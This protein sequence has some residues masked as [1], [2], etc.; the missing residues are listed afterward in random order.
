VHRA[1]HGQA[2][3]VCARV[4]GLC[5]GSDAAVMFAPP[6]E[7]HTPNAPVMFPHYVQ[8]CEVIA[9]SVAFSHN[10]GVHSVTDL[11]EYKQ[12]NC[13]LWKHSVIPRVYQLHA[14]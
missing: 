6:T 10:Q 12:I 14:I 5:T 4:F 13:V 2:R 9:I 8:S 7:E 1:T 11:P 3:H